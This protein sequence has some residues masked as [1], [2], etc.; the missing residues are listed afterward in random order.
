MFGAHQ[1]GQCGFLGVKSQRQWGLTGGKEMM[2]N[3]TG[4]REAGD[5]TQSEVKSLWKVLSQG[6]MCSNKF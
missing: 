2:E 6:G 3:F 1:E 5:L 4:Q